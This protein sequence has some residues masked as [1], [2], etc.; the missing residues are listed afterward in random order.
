MA[1][2][3]QKEIKDKKLE[4]SHGADKKEDKP[5]LFESVAE[6]LGYVAGTA[7]G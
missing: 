4:N 7:V 2:K 3:N 6:T 1:E 5:S